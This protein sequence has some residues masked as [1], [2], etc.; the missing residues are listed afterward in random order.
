MR[1]VRI[2]AVIMA[3]IAVQP[4]YS[5]K[6][7]KSMFDNVRN[8]HSLIVS[9]EHYN[10]HAEKKG[11]VASQT[12]MY[13]LKLPADTHEAK[14][15]TLTIA[16]LREAF[17]KD[18]SDAIR[19]YSRSA[20]ISMDEPKQ[21][22]IIS[23]GVSDIILGKH[24]QTSYILMT[25]PAPD[26]TVGNHRHVYAMEWLAKKDGSV[27]VKLVFDSSNVEKT[28][29]NGNEKINKYTDWIKE[30]R[31]QILN[32]RSSIKDINKGEFTHY[33]TGL[34]KLC[35]ECP[36]NDKAERKGYAEEIRSLAAEITTFTLEKQILDN[37][38]K[39]LER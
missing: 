29:T 14:N 15:E 12:D 11:N 31:Y 5:Q 23:S 27:E 1:K 36:I 3:A 34:Y 19:E 30:L 38:A 33:P 21:L 26:D 4:L 28:N 25:F 7:I 17:T 13:Y 39:N 32:L 8:M 16:E 24:P 9:E 2:A 35:L 20:E 22:K 37:A 10:D 18:R 6:N